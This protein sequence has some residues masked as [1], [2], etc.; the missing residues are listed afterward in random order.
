MHYYMAKCA[1]KLAHIYFAINQVDCW[2]S[3][4]AQQINIGVNISLF[5]SQSGDV[6]HIPHL[7]KQVEACQVPD[8]DPHALLGQ[9][10]N[11]FMHQRH[12]KPL[13]VMCY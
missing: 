1:I 7:E 11:V 9:L 12:N 13:S 5:A 6:M 10:S 4:D 3:V 8:S 2:L